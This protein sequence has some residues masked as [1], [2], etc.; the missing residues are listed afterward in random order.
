MVVIMVIFLLTLSEGLLLVISLHFSNDQFLIL[1]SNEYMFWNFRNNFGD[2]FWLFC[3]N[4]SVNVVSVEFLK[5]VENVFKVGEFMANI[6]Q[7]K[8]ITLHKQN[9]PMCL[10][11]WNP[12]SSTYLWRHTTFILPLI[13]LTKN[14]W[15]NWSQMCCEKLAIY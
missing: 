10:N 12:Y 8:L 14:R 5:K 1:V 11:F 9:K 2:M 6:Q 15:L 13:T 7:F 3:L 4:L